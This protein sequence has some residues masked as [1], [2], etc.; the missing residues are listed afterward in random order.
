MVYPTKIK[1]YRWVYWRR[2]LFTQVMVGWLR[3][4]LENEFCEDLE[5]M[6][7]LVP[8]AKLEN[9]LGREGEGDVTILLNL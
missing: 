6:A 7:R 1:A 4:L 8:A 2:K 3:L 9:K 5:S